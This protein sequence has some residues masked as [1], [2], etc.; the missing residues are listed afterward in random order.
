MLASVNIGFSIKKQVIGEVNYSD[1]FK[2]DYSSQ[3][4]KIGEIKIENDYFLPRRYELSAVLACL[5]DEDRAKPIV[6]AG[7][8]FFNEGETNRITPDFNL[9]E[10]SKATSSMYYSYSS[11][12]INVE[13]GANQEKSIILY[14]SPAY[15]YYRYDYNVY[16][17]YAFYD[18]IILVDKKNSKSMSCGS[19]SA[20]EIKQAKKI[21]IVNK[22]DA[23]LKLST[24]VTPSCTETDWY[25]SSG[26][27]NVEADAYNNLKYKTV[28]TCTD[29]N[30]AYTDYCVNSYELT[31]Y[32]CNPVMGEPKSCAENGFTTINCRTFGFSR[33]ENGACVY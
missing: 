32:A 30:G 8:V 17:D 22:Q 29:K 14:F 31:D 7:S 11:E 23:E 25:N 3:A 20:E 21:S 9:I 28:G 27:T 18:S 6:S 12:P 15:R 1:V 13:M 5:F 16:T 33:C 19:L 26:T 2:K 24:L 4:F 10:L